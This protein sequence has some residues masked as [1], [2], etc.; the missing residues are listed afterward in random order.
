MYPT[1]LTMRSIVSPYGKRGVPV[2][3]NPPS[4]AEGYVDTHPF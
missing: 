4:S 3:Y 2:A 1:L